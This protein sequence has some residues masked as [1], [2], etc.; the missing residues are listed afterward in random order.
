[1]FGVTLE[2]E[3][4]SKFSRSE[5][6]SVSNGMLELECWSDPPVSDPVNGS[7]LSS[8]TEDPDSL[9]VPLGSELDVKVGLIFAGLWLSL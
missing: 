8:E 9:L 7:V 5:G 6:G 2:F 3:C 4:S 1:V